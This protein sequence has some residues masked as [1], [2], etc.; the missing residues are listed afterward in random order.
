[1]STLHILLLLDGLGI[2]GAYHKR[3]HSSTEGSQHGSEGGLELLDFR[4][5]MILELLYQSCPT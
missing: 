3:S 4:D 1:M 2:F 5:W